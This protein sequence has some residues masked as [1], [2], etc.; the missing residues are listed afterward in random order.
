[1]PLD[2]DDRRRLT[3]AINEKLPNARC[4]L[5]QNENWRIA[6]DLSLIG[7]RYGLKQQAWPSQVGGYGIP[8][9]AITCTNCGNTH[10]LHLEELG[11]DS[12]L[13]PIRRPSPGDH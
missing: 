13:R 10:Q 8:T 11:L 2:P 5:C 4:P 1:M 6:P 12:D 9:V 3:E 7:L